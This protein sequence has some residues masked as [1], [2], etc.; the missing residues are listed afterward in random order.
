MQR[1]W[2]GTVCFFRRAEI[3]VKLVVLG[4]AGKARGGWIMP[5]QRVW[6][7]FFVK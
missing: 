2:V 1:L 7:L 6:I 5:W 3:S 4:E